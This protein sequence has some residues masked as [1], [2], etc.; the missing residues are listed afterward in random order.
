MIARARAHGR[1]RALRL[2][3]LLPI[4]T[5]TRLCAT[6]CACA[7]VSEHN[8]TKVEHLSQSCG[9]R[10]NELAHAHRLAARARERSSVFAGGSGVVVV[11]V[12]GPMRAVG[13]TN[14]AHKWN[15]V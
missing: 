10:H 15:C 7:C 3:P 8:I 1:G 11:V 9:W 13:G 6:F 14:D 12:A 5:R 4:E 2:L